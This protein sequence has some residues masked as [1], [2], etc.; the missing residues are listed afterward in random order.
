M[1]HPAAAAEMPH[2]AKSPAPAVAAMPA[3]EAALAVMPA[4]EEKGMGSVRLV[5]A[6]PRY[7]AVRRAATAAG[8]AVEGAAATAAAGC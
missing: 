6:E 7:R 8:S 2:L 1:V 3:P 5:A 4:Q